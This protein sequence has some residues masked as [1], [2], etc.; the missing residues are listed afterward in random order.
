MTRRKG[1]TL[2]E[3]LVVIAIIALLVGILLPSLAR[4]RDVA[5]RTVSSTHLKDMHIA[6]YQYSVANKDKFPSYR[7]GN[8]PGTAAFDEPVK[9]FAQGLRGQTTANTSNG[10]LPDDQLRTNVTAALWIGVREG[11]LTPE[12]FVNPSD[13][14]SNPDPY[15]SIGNAS[16]QFGWPGRF[17]QL[18]EAGTVSYQPAQTW[19]FGLP[20]SLRYSMA[21]MYDLLRGDDWSAVVHP[22][23][24]LMGDDNSATNSVTDP[25]RGFSQDNGPI[26]RTVGLHTLTGN[27]ATTNERDVQRCENSINHQ[28]EG[29][30][31]MFGDGHVAW[32]TDPFVGIGNDNVYAKDAAAGS[33]TDP[34]PAEVAEAPGASGGLTTG[35]DDPLTYTRNIRE[36]DSTLLPVTGNATINLAVQAGAY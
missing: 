28:G 11:A 7:R 35:G 23:A 6:Y 29:Q 8:D 34:F 27:T 13:T 3:L 30:N 22:E 19:D 21:N 18:G 17:D 14:L 9:A 12:Q 24:V 5:R 33:S 20:T 4:A 26:C 25:Q 15:L 2:I 36:R 1:F 32:H 31:F 10:G 16:G